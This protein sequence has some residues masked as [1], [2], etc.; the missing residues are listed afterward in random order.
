MAPPTLL[1]LVGPAAFVG[2]PPPIFFLG[3]NFGFLR[4]EAKVYVLN[5]LGP[6]LF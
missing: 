3:S 5:L 1:L 4:S 6:L 2:P